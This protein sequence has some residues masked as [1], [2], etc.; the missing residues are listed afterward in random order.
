M[1]A[2]NVASSAAQPETAAL[3]ERDR[4]NH[5]E[6]SAEYEAKVP[7]NRRGTDQEIAN[8]VAFLA[9]DLAGFITGAFLP[10]CG[11]KVFVSI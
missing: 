8:A 11:G 1:D 3:S 5:T 7:L 9:S 4:E 10:V 6:R 2:A